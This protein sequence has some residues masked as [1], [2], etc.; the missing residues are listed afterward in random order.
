MSHK[1][2]YVRSGGS[3]TTPG[4]A[5]VYVPF[6]R[7]G[8]SASEVEFVPSDAARSLI[9][10]DEPSSESWAGEQQLPDKLE[11]PMSA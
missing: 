10:D 5:R 8:N 11:T 2:C 3:S 1:Y 7:V 4:S 9:P 6:R